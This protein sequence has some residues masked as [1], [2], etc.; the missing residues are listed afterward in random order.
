MEDSGLTFSLQA[1]LVRHEAYIAEAEEARRQMSKRIDILEMDKRN[2][3]A[4]N[5]KTV[6]ENRELLDHLDQLNNTVSKSENHVGCLEATLHSTHLE[7]RRLE[8]L[9]SRTHDLEEQLVELE[10]EHESLKETVMLTEEE[11]RNAIRR[12]KEAERRLGEVQEQLERIERE[13]REERERH[14]EVLRRMERQKLVDKELHGGKATLPATSHS[15]NGTNVVSHFVKDILQDNVNLQMGIVELR[16]MLMTSNDEVHKLREQ[17]MAHQPIRDDGVED[18]TASSTLKAELAAK[19]P[20][21]FSQ[22]LHVHHHYHV[23]A[24]K[25][26]VRRPVQRKKRNVSIN[27]QTST[28]PRANS[29]SHRTRPSQSSVAATILSQTSITVPSPRTP[30]RWSM[31][32][33]NAPSDFASSAPSSPQS[34][35]RNSI[36][37]DRM[38][39]D[40]NVDFSRPTS[41]LSSI[42]P[43]SPVFKPM[44]RR[45]PSE[46]SIHSFKGPPVFET[47]TIHE[48]EDNDVSRHAGLE[49][50]SSSELVSQDD[51]NLGLDS[52]GPSSGVDPYASHD[53]QPKLR[54]S[55]SHESVLSISGTDI[56]TLKSRPSQLTITGSHAMLRPRTGQ[57]LSSPSTSFVST[58]PI[59]SSAESG[60]TT[61]SRQNYDSS[62]LLRSTM[63]ISSRP[64][65]RGSATSSNG[66]DSETKKSGGWIWSRWGMSPSPSHS[67]TTSPNCSVKGVPP[68]ALRKLTQRAVSTPITVDSNKDPLRMLVGRPPG[69]NQKGPIPGFR[70]VQKAPS[71]VTP[72]RVDWESLREVLEE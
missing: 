35:F 47:G 62:S 48:E 46:Y 65:S 57:G 58:Q 5:A 68:P 26:E 31:Q 52:T 25:E 2:L 9:A 38:S 56:H 37:F 15:K 53:Y 17:L 20:P 13:A 24:K 8:A 11:E 28:P 40:Q 18:D 30:N 45:H 23:P 50:P 1:L 29:R 61:I 10:K 12:W 33:F 49:A 36:L 39:I 64:V 66:A 44:H 42:D 4:E 59:F 19:E 27:L 60:T 54:R 63:G 55:T 22:E 43:M 14:D 7:L 32:S 34:N 21:P 70:R 3:E 67:T 72:E 6:Q 69:I 41:P 16:D 71:Q 51:S